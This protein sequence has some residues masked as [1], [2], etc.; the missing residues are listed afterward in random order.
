MVIVGG[1]AVGVELAGEIAVTFPD[2][3]VTLVHSG[4]HLVTSEFGDKFT[5]Q[6]EAALHYYSSTVTVI[7]GSNPTKY[8]FFTSSAY[9]FLFGRFGIDHMGFFCFR[10]Q[11]M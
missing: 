4:D 9:Y 7:K 1:G 8:I 3:Q 11:D 5:T 10:G 2:K 6:I